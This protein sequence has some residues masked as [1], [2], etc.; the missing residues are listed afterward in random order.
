MVTRLSGQI[1]SISNAV[2][3]SPSEA[4][5]ACDHQDAAQHVYVRGGQ[6]TAAVSSKFG[7]SVFMSVYPVNLCFRHR[8]ILSCGRCK[9]QLQ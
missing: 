5:Y 9:Q 1:I 4:A 2:G 7:G 8:P 3:W 6:T